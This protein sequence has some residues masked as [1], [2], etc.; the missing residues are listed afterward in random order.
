MK[1]TISCEPWQVASGNVY[2]RCEIKGYG[3]IKCYEKII[4]EDWF[5]DESVVKRIILTMADDLQKI[6]IKENPPLKGQ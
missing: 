3:D 6:Y 2:L 5:C 1:I 4:P